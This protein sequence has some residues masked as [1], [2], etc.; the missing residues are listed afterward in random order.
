MIYV[1]ILLNNCCYMLVE[2]FFFRIFFVVCFCFFFFVIQTHTHT[3]SHTLYN[4]FIYLVCMK[5]FFLT[6]SQSLSISF[7]LTRSLQKSNF[8]FA[9]VIRIVRFNENLSISMCEFIWIVTTL[10]LF[11]KT[12]IKFINDIWC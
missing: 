8:S 10:L 1:H 4:Y 3:L 11:L 6:L 5:K 9:R 12:K 2:C 7:S